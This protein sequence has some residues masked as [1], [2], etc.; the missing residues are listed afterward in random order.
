MLWHCSRTSSLLLFY[1]HGW[2]PPKT[3]DYPHE[4][5]REM[6]IQGSFCRPS[7][8]QVAIPSHVFVPLA[9]IPWLINLPHLS[10]WG[11]T[12]VYARLVLQFPSN[13]VSQEAVPV[14]RAALDGSI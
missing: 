14:D 1:K 5:G 4:A 9:M 3:S 12:Q 6:K 2:E 7:K 13:P 8:C 10:S 11:T